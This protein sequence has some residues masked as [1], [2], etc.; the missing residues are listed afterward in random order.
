MS[1]RNLDWDITFQQGQ[2]GE[3]L[4]DK[5]LGDCEIEVK[6]DIRWNQTGNIYI[7]SECWN[8]TN[9][10]YELSGITTTKASHWAFVLGEAIIIVPTQRVREAFID[11]KDVQCNEGQNP[12]HGRIIT[13]LDL[14]DLCR[15]L[16]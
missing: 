4:V 13:P 11:G 14:L 7:E 6:R 3:R 10:H 2:D 5:V 12:S 1:E 16:N 15:I 9:N 8:R